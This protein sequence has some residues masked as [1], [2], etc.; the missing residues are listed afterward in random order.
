MPRN[1]LTYP[2]NMAALQTVKMSHP[3]NAA[4]SSS[5]FDPSPW[6]QPNG[7]R[8][9]LREAAVPGC[10][11][12]LIIITASVMAIKKCDGP[13]ARRGQLMMTRDDLQLLTSCCSCRTLWT[14]I[15]S[16]RLL[17]ARSTTFHLCIRKESVFFFLPSECYS[18]IQG[19]RFPPPTL[20][21][22]KPTRAPRP[23]CC[24]NFTLRL[25]FH[26]F[27]AG[28]VYT[29]CGVR[30]ITV[31]V[32]ASAGLGFLEP[33]QANLKLTAWKIRLPF[34]PFVSA[35]TADERVAD[36]EGQRQRHP[37]RIRCRIIPSP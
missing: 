34:G 32:C 17:Y 3:P 36:R 20:L 23:R 25:D 37:G 30:E 26:P 24:L 35:P 19:E 5:N 14:D 31:C 33:P 10:S 12:L 4:S 6:C 2:A 29:G 11:Y 8:P 7:R 15:C 28:L 22:L 1:V 16:I 27:R 18:Q 21:N 9:L 13:S